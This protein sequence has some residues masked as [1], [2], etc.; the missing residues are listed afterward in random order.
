MKNLLA[1][2][3]AAAPITALAL[4]PSQPV[5]RLDSAGEIVERRQQLPNRYGSTVNYR[6]ASYRWEADGWRAA[7]IR[8]ETNSVTVEIP[9]PIQAVAA[10]YKTALEGIYGAGAVTNRALTR[11]AVA[12]DLSLREDVSA[13]TGLRLQAWF[14]ILNEYWQKGE[15]WTFPYDAAEYTNTTTTTVWEVTDNE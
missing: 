10:A 2:L 3:I 8:T 14:E 5:V 13:E 6:S 1:I 15:I 9:Q 7:T 11:A 12:I 4:N